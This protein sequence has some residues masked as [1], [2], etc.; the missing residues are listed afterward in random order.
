MTLKTGIDRLKTEI[1]ALEKAIARTWPQP[2]EI[3]ILN[4]PESEDL[5]AP[6]RL[7]PEQIEAMGGVIEIGAYPQ[8]GVD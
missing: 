8:P 5:L 6:Y 1:A 4:D 3:L 7:T 2:V